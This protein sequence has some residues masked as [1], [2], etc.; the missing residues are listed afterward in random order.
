M[1]VALKAYTHLDSIFRFSPM[2]IKIQ[3][4]SAG[5]KSELYLPPISEIGKFHTVHLIFGG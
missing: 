2:I 5:L 4:L 1:I 3:L